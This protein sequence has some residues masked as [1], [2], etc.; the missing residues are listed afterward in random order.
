MVALGPDTLWNVASLPFYAN[1]TQRRD[2]RSIPNRVF[3]VKQ[4]VYSVISHPVAV[5]FEV[6]L[7]W[8]TFG[9]LM[10][11]S[12]VLAL[13]WL[14]IAVAILTVRALSQRVSPRSG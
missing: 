1:E 2:N 9:T 6:L 5:Y 11:F 8:A 14:G 13:G 4:T 7:W 3:H 12:Q 10:G